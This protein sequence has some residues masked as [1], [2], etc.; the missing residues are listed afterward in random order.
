MTE[1]NRLPSHTGMPHGLPLDD[2][3]ESGASD[4]IARIEREIERLADVAERCRKLMSGAKAAIVLG[5]VLLA[6]ILIGLV[7][8]EG[9][10]LIAALAAII[11]GIVVLGSNATT[12]RQTLE[13]MA[14]REAHRSALIDRL[15]L[16]AV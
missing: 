1:Q 5:G 2:E 9:G 12:R 15:D 6:L 4:D 16:H 13:A 7:R 8:A 3:D 11:G 10:P 14:V